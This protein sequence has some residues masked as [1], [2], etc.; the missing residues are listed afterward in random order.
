[1]GALCQ[2]MTEDLELKNYAPATCKEY[3]ACARRFVA[4]HMRPPATMG[5]RE[6]RDFLLDLAL[7]RQAKP[8]TLKM[9]VAALKFLYAT[10]LRR[11]EEVVR[12][13]WPKVPRRLPDILSLEEVATVLAAVETVLHR[14][15]VMTAY[16]AGLRIHEACSLHVGDIDSKRGVIHVR[17][18]KGAR[19]RYVMLPD[20]LLVSLRE[21]FREVR[22]SGPRLFPGRKPGRAIT[23][24]TV[25]RALRKALA[26]AGI[27]KRVTMH[28]LR[29]SSATHL[30]EAG[31][32][33]RVIQVLLGHASIRTTTRYTHVSARHVAS[34]KSPLDRLPHKTPAAVKR[35]PERL[36]HKAPPR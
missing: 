32:D 24:K 28:A 17:Q 15:V 36:P 34:V 22:P 35:P 27:K 14:A 11:P 20:R 13:S 10:T 3:L 30:L 9:H 33:I 4:F 16:G 21:Y 5:E 2:R 25:S 31:T 7:S 1:M 8:A 6:I 12:L 18:G 26:K 29:H 23:P 19:D